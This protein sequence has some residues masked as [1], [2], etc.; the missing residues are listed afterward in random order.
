MK[1]LRMLEYLYKLSKVLIPLFMLVPM[2]LSEFLPN[3][4]YTSKNEKFLHH[5]VPS[6]LHIL[7]AII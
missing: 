5:A 4:R 6:S 3:L 7:N 1:Q 2:P